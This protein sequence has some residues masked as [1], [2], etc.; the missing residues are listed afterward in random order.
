MQENVMN[1]YGLTQLMWAYSKR[2]STDVRCDAWVDY[3]KD[4][5]D[6]LGSAPF[7]LATNPRVPPDLCEYWLKVAEGKSE[8]YLAETGARKR[9]EKK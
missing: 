3:A 6:L 5:R 2:V 1:L 8:H 7:D 4:C 9:K